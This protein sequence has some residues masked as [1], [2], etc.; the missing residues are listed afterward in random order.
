MKSRLSNLQLNSNSLNVLETTNKSITGRIFH[1]HTYI[2][3]D[4]RTLLGT[5]LKTYLE[6]GSY[7]GSSASLML[8]HPYETNIICVEPCVLD[9]SHYGGII[10][11]YHTLEKTLQI[12][13]K[14]NYS[15]S[16]EKNFSH[17]IKLLTKFK[18][19]NLKIDILFI[20]GGH[21][22][23]DVIQDWNNYKDFV[24]PGGFIIFD[25]YC[26]KTYSPEVKPAVDDIVKNLNTDSYEIIGSID[27]IHN[28]NQGDLT[29]KY[30][31]NINEFIIYK[32]LLNE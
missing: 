20:D 3:Y 22:Y 7:I 26:D 15:F 16:I 31:N 28:L 10:D 17:D 18:T 30:P 24:N 32:K 23:D 13:N 9:K 27:N 11:Q 19:Y 5:N 29:Y 14:N 1:K 4:I 25:D 6:I 8:N 12:N 2:L 21:D